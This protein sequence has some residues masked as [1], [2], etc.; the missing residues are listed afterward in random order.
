MGKGTEGRS[1]K[2][3]NMEHGPSWQTYSRAARQKVSAF[4]GN[5]KFITMFTAD[6]HWILSWARR[7]QSTSPRLIS[8]R[9][10]I[11]IIVVLQGLG[12]LACSGSEFIFWNVRIYWTV[13]TTPWTGDQPIAIPLPTQNSTRQ[14]KADTHTCLKRDSNPGSQSSRG[15]RP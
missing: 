9:F 15:P 13:G 2:K 11:I 7:I 14:R 4:H 8:L 3:H 12:L 10:I 5:R 6:R 1:D